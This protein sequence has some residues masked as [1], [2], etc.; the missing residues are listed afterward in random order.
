MRLGDWSFDRVAGAPSSR[1]GARRGTGQLAVP[2]LILER[3]PKAAWVQFADAV[4]LRALTS[5]LRP[6]RIERATLLA[7]ESTDRTKIWAISRG[8]RADRAGYKVATPTHVSPGMDLRPFLEQGFRSSSAG[9]ALTLLPDILIGSAGLD[10]GVRGQRRADA[11]GQVLCPREA[12]GRGKAFTPHHGVH[13]SAFPPLRR[14]C[15]A[16]AT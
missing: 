14:R 7:D 16:D 12:P 15:P 10:G 5:C 9:R 3:E 6:G 1:G 2:T 8:K 13:Y 11:K 4:I